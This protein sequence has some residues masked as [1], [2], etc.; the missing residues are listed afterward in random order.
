M[1]DDDKRPSEPGGMVTHL[2]LPYMVRARVVADDDA[3]PQV[4]EFRVVA[5]SV[6]EA[7][8]QVCVEAGSVSL[9]DAKVKIE[10]IKPDEQAYRTMFYGEI[11]AAMNM[12]RKPR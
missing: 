12:V 1:S 5:Y 10:E 9:D 6:F 7:M 3:P 11:Q 8:M 2:P 4:R